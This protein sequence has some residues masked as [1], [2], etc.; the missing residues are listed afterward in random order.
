MI[1][2]LP[3]IFFRLAKPLL[4]YRI[5]AWVSCVVLFAL[6]LISGLL[7]EHGSSIRRV[8]STLSLLLF[9]QVFFSALFLE[10]YRIRRSQ[11]KLDNSYFFY[12]VNEW[13]MGILAP[14]VC[15]IILLLEISLVLGG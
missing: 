9:I 12:E 13:C 14:G 11:N 6:L 2:N 7:F 15:L 10:T 3:N 1:T 5:A 8:V 4:K